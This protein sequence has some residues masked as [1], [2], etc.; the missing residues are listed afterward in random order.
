[1]ASVPPPELPEGILPGVLRALVDRR[2]AAKRDM[3]NA[4]K[5]EAERQRADIKQRALK[6]V[7]NSMYGCLGFEHSRFFCQP[8][9]AL[10]TAQ[11]RDTLQKTKE[12]AEELAD[13]KVREKYTFKTVALDLCD[14]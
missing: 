1:M 7:A 4:G 10:I 8:L 11:G 9:A 13:V 3:N 5:S 2:R 12:Q 14:L 6:L